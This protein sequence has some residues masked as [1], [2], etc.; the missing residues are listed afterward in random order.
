MTEEQLRAVELNPNEHHLIFG[1]PGSGKTQIL[2]HRAAYLRDL[3]G[4][5]P[6]RFCIFV[7][8]NALKQ[9]IQSAMAFL[10]L[11]E[12]NVLTF[13]YWCNK[14][15]Q[16]Y[17]SR[18]IP[19][20]YGRH[21]PDYA[22]VR[23]QVLER[24]HSGNGRFLYDFVLVDEGQDLDPDAFE[25]IRLIARHITVCMDNK[26]Q[27]YEAGSSESDIL[28]AL[29]LRRKNVA[30]LSTFRCCP[31]IA[32]VASRFIEDPTARKNYLNQ[33]RIAQSERQKPLLYFS[34][35]EQDEKNRLIDV[36]K[37]RQN[38]GDRMAVLYPTNQH[39]LNNARALMIA[40][41]E[42]EVLQKPGDRSVFSPIDFNSD[43]PKLMTYHS[44]KGLT[45]DSVILPRLQ[46]GAFARMQNVSIKRLIF[47]AITRATKWVYLSSR[48][49]NALPMMEQLKR[50]L[51]GDCLAVQRAGELNDRSAHADPR[52]R[53]GDLGDLL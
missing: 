51:S 8:T 3:L 4:T 18:S 40:G 6:E 22:A 50:H 32:Q 5:A 41:L 26:Q 35:D 24:L 38:L 44:V 29:G 21:S 47:V 23:R 39:V 30:L 11:P 49:G 2:L 14:F 33:T 19:W 17:I 37:T 15:Y 48:I 34:R 10:D 28:A 31:Y 1:G 25:T 43:C 9:Y 52:T 42:V 16:K 13:D 7:F 45:F 12:E 36:I 27:I 20:D 53:R 46:P